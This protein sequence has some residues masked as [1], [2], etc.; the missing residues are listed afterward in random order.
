MRLGWRRQL[1]SGWGVV[2]EV[3]QGRLV[4]RKDYFPRTYRI[5]LPVLS[6]NVALITESIMG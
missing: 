2:G 5:K 1:T 6:F 3:S 4:H